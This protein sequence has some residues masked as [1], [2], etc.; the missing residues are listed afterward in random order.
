MRVGA[1]I[2]RRG[3]RIFGE[4]L[5]GFE[6]TLSVEHGL[7]NLEIARATAQHAAERGLDHGEVQLLDTAQEIERSHQHARGA[8]AALGGAVM[9]KGALQ[10]P[11]DRIVRDAFDG[12]HPPALELCRRNEAGA[13]LL[14]VDEHR[15]GA[16]I[17]GVAA[18]LGAGEAELLAQHARQAHVGTRGDL[19]LLVVDGEHD[20]ACEL[21]RDHAA[22]PSARGSMKAA[23]AR[24]TRMRAAS[25][26]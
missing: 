23:S 9:M 1:S 8:D 13:G 3:D 26:R 24:R 2:S 20:R 11:P 12:L 25:R 16:A 10:R 14:L 18:D 7:A 17:A 4:P 5:I 19:D 6:E 15:A 21:L 22:T